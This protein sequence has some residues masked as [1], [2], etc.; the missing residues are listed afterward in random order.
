MIK[1]KLKGCVVFTSSV[2]AYIPS[3]FSAMYGATKAFVSNLA[4]SLA[5][6]VSARGIDLL[7][8]HPSPISTSF[9]DAV[10]RTYILLVFFSKKMSVA[11]NTL[12]KEIFKSVGRVVWRDL[13][14]MALGVRMGT[15]M[16]SYSFLAHSFAT[17][18]PFMA[19]YKKN[20]AGR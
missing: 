8:V 12:P 11:P 16:L 19:D 1:E 14:G 7:S 3:P 13:G 9:A 5:V 4:A 2:V 18:A 17:F 15:K 6:E 10:L 20:N